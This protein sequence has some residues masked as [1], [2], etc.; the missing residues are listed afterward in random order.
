MFFSPMS[1]DPIALA[2]AED[3]GERAED[4]TVA[5]F[6]APKQTARARIFAKEP[7]VVAGV[8]TA[9]ETFRRV[10]PT[11]EV[12]ATVPD[13]T[14]VSPGDTVLTVA[15]RAARGRSSPANVWR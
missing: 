6:V 4:A 9:A 11:L 10:E 7:A 1:H 2:L 12:V 8:E 5:F 3:L 13:G 14:R 15:G